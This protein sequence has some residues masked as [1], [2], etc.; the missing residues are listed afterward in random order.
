MVKLSVDQ[1]SLQ[2]LAATLRGM[3]SS[4]TKEASIAVNKVA[5]KVKLEAARALNKAIPVKVSILKKAIRITRLASPKESI[6]EI[7]LK[8]GYPIPLKYFG[9]TKV[10]TKKGGVTFRLMRAHKRKSVGRDLFIVEKYKGHVFR[11][12]GKERGPLV[13]MNGPA[14]GD[15]YKEAG[16]V[17]VAMRVAQERLPLELKERIRFLTAKAAGRLRGKQRT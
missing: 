8:E 4:I 5:K 6:A 3:G 10:N 13:R 2:K 1:A 12:E 11:R 7:T 9:A 16:V 17:A 14:P 15:V